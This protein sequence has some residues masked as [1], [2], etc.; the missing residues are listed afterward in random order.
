MNLRGTYTLTVS[1]INGCTQTDNITITPGISEIH[2]KVYQ[3]PAR[4]YLIDYD[5]IMGTLTAIDSFDITQDSNAFIFNNLPPNHQYL[6]KAAPLPLFTPSNYFPTYYYKALFW[7]D[8][9]GITTSSISNSVFISLVEGS[10]PGGPGFIGGLISEGANFTQTGGSTEDEGDPLANQIIHLL[11]QDDTPVT[12]TYTN[13]NG[14]FSL[15]N[16]PYG[17]YKLVLDILNKN[18]ATKYLTLSPDH[19]STNVQFIVNEKNVVV[20]NIQLNKTVPS[21][22]VLPNP[23]LDEISIFIQSPK[24]VDA[25][26]TLTSSTGKTVITR[27]QVL[28][29]N[30]NIKLDISTLPSGT[31]FIHLQTNNKVLTQKIIKL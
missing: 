6:I 17:N 14:A 25:S 27:D 16:L 7:N 11:K 3:F 10:N 18:R 9:D 26:I 2:G 13:V 19:A 24:N 29:P 31:Y 21:F 30:N 1:D 5:S 28:N 8:A 22:T 20:S 12:Y 4:A 23:A 15:D